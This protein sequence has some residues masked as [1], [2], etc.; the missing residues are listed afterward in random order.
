MEKEFFKN[1]SV[2][3]EKLQSYN[4]MLGEPIT[5]TP[6]QQLE[7]YEP[8]ILDFRPVVQSVD[9]NQ[10]QLN[11]EE[12]VRTGRIVKPMTL[13]LSQQPIQSSFKKFHT[14][15]EVMV[16]MSQN[17]NAGVVNSVEKFK[18]F[19]GVSTKEEVDEK[20]E[21]YL[22]MLKGLSNDQQEE[23]VKK[24]SLLTETPEEKERTR[25]HKLQE[26]QRKEFAQQVDLQREK[27]LKKEIQMKFKVFCSV[28]LEMKDEI[29][30][31]VKSFTTRSTF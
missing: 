21:E 12:W 18:E 13:D 3:E 4:N 29:K 14:L 28:I 26:E 1:F 23:L 25:L 20:C 31:V 10:Q 5:Q 27:E 9:T 19:F 22:K 16:F 6:K 7:N 2:P 15:E 17:M 8:M 24:L 30:E 11:Y